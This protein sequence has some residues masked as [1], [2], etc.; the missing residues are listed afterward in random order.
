MEG[1]VVGHLTE[2]GGDAFRLLQIEA[3]ALAG[4]AE[5]DQKLQPVLLGRRENDPLQD[6]EVLR[7]GRNGAGRGLLASCRPQPEFRPDFL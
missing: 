2:G 3:D 1:G 7:F 6:E 5:A 4:L